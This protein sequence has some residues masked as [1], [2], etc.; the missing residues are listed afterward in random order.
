MCVLTPD[1]IIN[2]SINQN[3]VY[4]ITITP[5]NNRQKSYTNCIINNNRK[6]QKKMDVKTVGSIYY[7]NFVST[8][9]NWNENRHLQ[10]TVGSLHTYKD[11]SAWE[12]P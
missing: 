11:P 12:S 5:I 4:Q 1:L 7:E 3:N 6:M 8:P 9:Q 10:Y 2:Q